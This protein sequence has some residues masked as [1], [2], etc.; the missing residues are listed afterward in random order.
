MT[1]Q[2][3]IDTIVAAIKHADVLDNTPTTD[4]VW[5]HFGWTPSLD[6]NGLKQYTKGIVKVHFV[7]RFAPGENDS[8]KLTFYVATATVMGCDLDSEHSGIDDQGNLNTQLTI[9]RQPVL[10]LSLLASIERNYRSI[11]ESE[12]DE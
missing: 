5:E 12:V 4:E 2:E 10:H 11:F 6:E 9:S 7:I 8:E 1:G 3:Q